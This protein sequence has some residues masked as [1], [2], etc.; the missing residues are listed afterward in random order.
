MFNILNYFKK[1]E[2]YQTIVDNITKSKN[3]GLYNSSLNIQKLITIELFKK[4]NKT[5]NK[6]S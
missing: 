3:S 2:K 5:R 1:I 4:T 6:R